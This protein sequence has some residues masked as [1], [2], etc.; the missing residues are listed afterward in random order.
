MKNDEIFNLLLQKENETL[1][2]LSKNKL[3][4]DDLMNSLVQV[5]E[6]QRERILFLEEE[7]L[8]INNKN[9]DLEIKLKDL[10]FK[11]SSRNISSSCSITYNNQSNYID[12]K[13]NKLDLNNIRSF[14]N[15][16]GLGNSVNFNSS[17]FN[18]YNNRNVDSISNNSRPNSKKK[19]LT[20]IYK[21]K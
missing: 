18:F 12:N 2:K 20:P 8:T 1:K 5:L 7:N 14:T 19:V 17:N 16:N 13:N 21:N 10:E 15:F 9:K 4:G 6:L 11:L 3:E